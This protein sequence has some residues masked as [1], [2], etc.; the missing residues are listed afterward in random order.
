MFLKRRTL[1]AEYFDE[2]DRPQA[3]LVEGY[4]ILGRFNRLFMLARSF[5]T[6]VPHFLGEIR[7]RKLSLL[8]LGAGDGF[9][10]KQLAG[11]ASEMGWDWKV[12]NFDL[13]PRAL[14]LSGT[15]GCVAGSALALPFREQSFDV[16]IASQMTHHFMADSEVRNHFKEA[17]RTTGG[18]LLITDL[19][20]NLAF[21]LAMQAIL[22][23][24]GVPAHFRSDAL[25]SVKRGWR[26]NDWKSL[27]DEAGIPEAKVWLYAGTRIMLQAQRKC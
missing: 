17:W 26:V 9:L 10:T 14:K 15:D 8:D 3:D 19:H 25:L 18:L 1:Q 11:W 13:N 20:R 24:S 6:L 5:Q 12:T 7:C 23:I 21:Y 4:R 16:V 22:R 2:P 27:A